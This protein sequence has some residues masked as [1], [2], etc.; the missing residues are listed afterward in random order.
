[1]YP[2]GS[3]PLKILRNKAKAGNIN[4]YMYML[5]NYGDAKD[6]VKLS[7]RCVLLYSSEKCMY[8]LE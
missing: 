4:L 6:K 5:S 7:L 1:M 2:Y 8:Q 3:Y